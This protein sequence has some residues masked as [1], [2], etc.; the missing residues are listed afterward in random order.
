M[1]RGKLNKE[2][3]LPL[4]RKFVVILLLFSSASCY[5]SDPGD[6]DSG[7]IIGLKPIYMEKADAHDIKF[8]EPKP[9]N[10]PGKIYTYGSVLFINEIN[11]GIHI[12]DNSDPKKPLPLKFIS[13]YGNVDL[14]VKSDILY[15]DNAGDL[16]ALN[17]EDL[18]NIS[19]VKRVEN[20]FPSNNFP[21]QT[22]VYFECVDPSK[23]VVVGWEETTLTTLTCRR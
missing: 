22:G 20:V 8:E 13:I 11:K 12:I 16:I 21:A 19:V 5:H 17:I 4:A 10:N 18:S 2:G 7:P 9:L 1:K 23:G 6:V 3:M 15:A 14:A